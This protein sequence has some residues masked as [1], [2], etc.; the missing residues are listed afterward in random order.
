MPVRI[1]ADTVSKL[2]DLPV[3]LDRHHAVTSELL[4]GASIRCGWV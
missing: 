2:S 1:V 3:M 4:S